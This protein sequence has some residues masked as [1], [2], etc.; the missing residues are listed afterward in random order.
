M[1]RSGGHMEPFR[2]AVLRM[3]SVFVDVSL[4]MLKIDAA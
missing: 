1:S 4:A 3:V 2:H